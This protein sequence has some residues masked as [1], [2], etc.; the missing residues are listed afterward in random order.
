MFHQYVTN[1]EFADSPTGLNL[2]NLI[3]SGSDT[4]EGQALTRLLQR[5]SEIVDMH[6]Q[7][8]LYAEQR[9]DTFRIYPDVNGNLVIKARKFPVTNVI[10]L[11]YAVN[12]QAGFTVVDSSTIMIDQASIRNWFAPMG[13]SVDYALCHQYS[14]K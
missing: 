9:T 4:Q 11:Q 5:A 8:T 10:S 12:P 7:Q 3:P 6:C 2:D 14:R 1:Q 13:V